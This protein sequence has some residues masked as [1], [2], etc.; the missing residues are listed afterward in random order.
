MAESAKLVT[1][2]EQRFDPEQNRVITTLYGMTHTGEVGILD[3]VVITVEA[4]VR[5]YE[6]QKRTMEQIQRDQ[7]QA[8]IETMPKGRRRKASSNVVQIKRG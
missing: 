4:F 1:R 7:A 6:M 8:F 2:A 3:T 5:S